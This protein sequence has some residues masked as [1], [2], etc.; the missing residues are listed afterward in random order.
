L[1]VGWGKA[2]ERKG[3]MKPRIR[4]ESGIVLVVTLCFTMIVAIGVAA[5]L[6]LTKTQVVQVRNQLHSA[7][8]FYAAEAG[9]EKATKLLKDDLYYTPKG[10]E[11]SWAD[12]KIYTAT[13]FI[14]LQI[15]K[16]LNPKAPHY[17]SDF[18]PLL[19]ETDYNT[20]S[21]GAH[22]STYMVDL[23]NLS[24][25]S[26]RV[27]VKATGRYYRR[28]PGGSGY[29]MQAERT[30]L[31]LLRGREI[32]PWN[33]AIFAGEGHQGKIINGNVDIRGSVHLL[34]TSLSSSDIAADFSGTAGIG[35][36]YSWMPVVLASRVPPIAKNYGGQMLESLES[37]VRIQ[38]GKLA[39]SGTA[40]VGQQ[41]IPGNSVKETVEGVYITD[42]YGGNSGEANVYSDNGT[43]NAYDLDEFSIKFPRL[44][45]PYQGYPT[46]LD[47]LKPNALV[48]SD[49]TR[50][51]QL[52]N[53]SPASQFSYSDTKG[54]IGMDGAGHLRIRGIVVV[55]GDL[56]FNKTASLKTIEYEGK[57][58]VACAGNVGINCDLITRYLSTF[59]TTDILGVMAAN[60]IV[61][62]SAQI[63]VMGVFYAENQIISKKQT[64]VAGTFFSNYFDMGTNVP[65]IYQV[66]EVVRN[67]PAGMI[68]DFRVWVVKRLTWGEI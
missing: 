53:I 12:S 18:Y 67:L 5:F 25:W 24:G 46:Y 13:G 57:G 64:S 20:E 49:S 65:A 43:K 39:L 16:Y 4:K 40:V 35:N 58:T 17:D 61:F 68:G 45:N 38:H 29:T 56:N 3:N 27:W 15:Q 48:I 52:R 66:P 19:E 41:D 33:N 60:A 6:Q 23:S 62:D 30:I 7:K 54:E 44:S 9:L 8:A 34:G 22:K 59:P 47:Y 37:E 51:N 55:E 36:N 1:S 50:L 14:I 42:G 10:I 11:P 63:N 21:N 28:N 32:S 2:D 26:D 31:A